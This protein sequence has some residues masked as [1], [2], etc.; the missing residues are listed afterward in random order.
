MRRNAIHEAVRRFA[1]RQHG[2]FSA[3]GQMNREITHGATISVHKSQYVTQ[4]LR[5][6]PPT[7]FYQIINAKLRNDET[8][9]TGLIAPSLD[10]RHVT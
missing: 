2:V 6:R 1:D 5:R 10:E 8:V 9:G 7:Y 4:F 3:D